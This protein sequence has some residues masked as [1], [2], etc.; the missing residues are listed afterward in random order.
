MYLCR[1]I[2]LLFDAY[3][4]FFFSLKYSSYLAII[5]APF[6][7]KKWFSSYRKSNVESDALL[8]PSMFFMQMKRIRITI[9][10]FSTIWWCSYVQKF[11]SERELKSTAPHCVR[12]N[13]N[14]SWVQLPLITCSNIGSH[15]ASNTKAIFELIFSGSSCVCFSLLLLLFRNLCFSVCNPVKWWS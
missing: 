6:V 8:D 10:S 2:W 4:L 11:L 1:T 7:L 15:I 9:V 12:E 3:N 14:L 5:L 13:K